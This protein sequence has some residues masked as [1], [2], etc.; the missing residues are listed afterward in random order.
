MTKIVRGGQSGALDHIN[1]S[2]SV[3]RT[4]I[5]ALTDAVRQLGGA[6]E[7]GAGAVTNDPLSAPYVLYVNPFTGSDKFVSGEYS[8]NGS[9][10]QRIALQRLEC[11]YT[12]ARP[13][14]SISRAIIEAGII[15]AKSYYQNPLANADLVSIILAPGVSILLNG[16]GDASV[17][18]WASG[19][20]PTNS[21]LQAFNPAATGGIILPRG[22][23]LCGIDL[24]KTIFRPDTVPSV[25]D[26]TN[27]TS[28]R[29]AIFKV[30][31]TGY[32]FGFTFKDK[33]G[34]TSSHHLLSCFEFASKNELDEFYAK[35][36][37]AFAGA[38]N[39]GGLDTALA[40]TRIGEYQIV[41]ARP[42]S[43]DQGI[44]TD[45]TLSASPYIF[46]CSIRS[47]YGLC[48]IFADGSKATGFR[49]MVV[50]QFTGVSLQ[51][52]L[53]CWQKYDAAQ[54][55]M[56]GAY[57]ANYAAYV[58]A[59]P[60]NV[61]M[62]PARRS[63]HI[64]A[65]NSAVIQEV[66]V[67]AIGQGIHH[68]VQ[69][70]GE[71]T[72]T[73]SNS[74]FGGCAAL[75]EG[76][77]STAYV[78][79]VNWNI[80]T[81]RVANNLAEKTNNVRKVYL[82]T[83]ANG[84]ADNAT[85][86]ILTEALANSGKNP[87]VPQILDRDGYTLRHN[88]YIWVENSR[89][90]DYRA[91]LVATPW[92]SA[93]PA[94][95]VISGAFS[96]QDGIIPGASI[97]NDQG[98]NTGQTWPALAGSRIYIRRVQDSRN[99]NERR[100]S[101]RCNNTD[102]TSR[103]P[104][105][106]FI[107]QTKPGSGSV[108]S[109]IPDSNLIVVSNAITISSDG[110]GANRSASVELRRNNSPNIWVS[111]TLYRLGDTVKYQNKTFSCVAQNKDT[112][113]TV[114]N[115]AES[116]VHME[117][118]YRP[119]D[120]WKNT[121]PSII[122]NN[123]TDSNDNTVNCGY[124]FTTVWSTDSEIQTQYRTA[125]DYRGLHLLLTSLGFSRVDSHTILLPRIESSRERN[126]DT[127]L[128]GIAAPSGA[129][130]AW[131][132]WA[133][134]FRRPSNIRLF[135]QAYEWAGYL[136][137]S[138]ALPEYQGELDPLNKFT[139]YFT[140]KN[141]GRVYG[142][143]F[144]EDGFLV[145]PQGL[146]DVATGAEVAFESIGDSD[147][148]IDEIDFPTFYDSL[149]VNNLT[150]NTELNLNSSSIS[151]TPVW[152]GGFGGALPVLPVASTTQTGIIEI[153]T[154]SEVQ[155]FLRNDLAVT[156]NT[157]IQALGDAIKSVV[158]LRISLSST[159]SVPNG[160]QLNS[161][162]VY[163]HPLN[164]NEVALYSTASLRWQ[165]VRFN[166]VQTISLSTANSANTNYDIY[167]YNNGSVLTPVL[168]LEY[169][170]WTNDTT[171]PTRSVQDG[172]RVRYNN[173]SRRLIGVVRTTSAGTSTIDLG[174]V[175]AGGSSADYPR[176]YLANLYNLY[177]ARAVYFFG[178][179][180]TTL[181]EDWAV[182]PAAIYSTAPRISW[183]Q[184]SE[185][186]TTVFMDVYN[187]TGGTILI[188]YVAPGID[189]TS[190]PPTDAFYGETQGNNQTVGSQWARALSAGKHDVYYLYKAFGGG[191]STINEHPA[192]GTILIAKI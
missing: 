128:D 35:I 181:T 52:D 42:S 64:R 7:I 144:N 155:E 159:S 179:S 10:T 70:G 148:P 74:N 44:D 172:V 3:F 186:L 192:H 118:E 14:R 80:G 25:T 60:N 161:T 48:G 23:S 138:K 168:A 33:E 173:P 176:M 164:G 13:F 19:K 75:A 157:L 93:T 24:R 59:N 8:T 141:G 66:S 120:Y 101:L 99:T 29:R 123:D 170:A 56:W 34:S 149:N 109:L 51:R 124:N 182:P 4:Q 9:A 90:L 5:A 97:V 95:I 89:G 146:Q 84:V 41:G 49:S 189:T 12:E 158:N 183:V 92:S 40:V 145:T 153:A 61:R 111:N 142:S 38:S 11:G 136:N 20:D 21:E 185:T 17:P 69:T 85:T 81:L 112:A 139:Y 65:I 63:F 154:A 165:V 46:N 58:N 131:D 180:W 125:T 68:W 36:R 22:V 171:R 50:A 102:T 115:W 127:A 82:G 163:I 134:E 87:G 130:T 94:N 88:S 174:G 147:V 6:A 107:L 73:N 1:S 105:R 132:N 39:T 45:T 37:S 119:E 150:I 104:V 110:A 191:T 32:Y 143:G 137:Y 187:N 175:I 116:Y 62:H 28:N 100:Y 121:Q 106:D 169:V 114:S 71:L 135:G 72:V 190:A 184:A 126:P 77:Q 78:A 129:A 86:I 166:G 151:G 108:T 47:N 96:N 54:S 27:N 178:S 18:E 67:F 53:S 177:D 160:N 76:Y 188:A 57:F 133:I 122:F 156:P 55:P 30:T 79:D 162:N 43:G 15:T 140:N 167:L 26:E 113:F 16:K 83:I 152:E 98:Y 117:E 103:T 2:Q 91:Q 31:G